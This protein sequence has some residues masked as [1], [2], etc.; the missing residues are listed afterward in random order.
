MSKPT[1]LKLKTHP[2]WDFKTE[3]DYIMG[4]DFPKYYNKEN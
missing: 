4:G 2:N 1:I 3:I